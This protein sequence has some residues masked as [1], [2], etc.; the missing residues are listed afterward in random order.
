MV[1]PLRLDPALA[2]AELFDALVACIV[3]GSTWV[4]SYTASCSPVP[5]LAIAAMVC[6]RAGT[7]I[8]KCSLIPS[9]A[10][11]LRLLLNFS[12]V[13]LLAPLK[14]LRSEFIPLSIQRHGRSHL[15]KLG[16]IPQPHRFRIVTSQACNHTQ[17][18]Q[19]R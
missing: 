5:F 6:T 7:E 3:D 12:S 1:S 2:P 9:K 17:V 15:R 4:R 11:L 18:A 14:Q 19:Q 16:I 13:T 8:T 10:H